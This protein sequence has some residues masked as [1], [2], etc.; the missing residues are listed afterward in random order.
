MIMIT[1]N[2]KFSGHLGKN[3]SQNI[4]GFRNQADPVL[5]FS[6][7]KLREVVVRITF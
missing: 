2:S 6:K 7:L 4:S 5:L 3:F 1:G